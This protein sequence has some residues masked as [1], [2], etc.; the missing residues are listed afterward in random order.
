MF[1]HGLVDDRSSKF[2]IL[3]RIM[4]LQNTTYLR[5]TYLSFCLICGLACSMF[6]A[7]FSAFMFFKEMDVFTEFF[8]NLILWTFVLILQETSF[9]MM[10]SY[11]FKSPSVARDFSFLLHFMMIYMV[12]YST[13]KKKF[14]FLQYMIPYYGI[15]N[16]ELQF[17]LGEMGYEL[18][19]YNIYY[20][21][22]YTVV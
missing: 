2:K 22:F 21:W 18:G 15:V 12:F 9:T 6:F 16:M 4:G 7:C 3:Y 10:I 8:G 1:A 13:F 17:G 11:L 20:E 14:L 5:A 19:D